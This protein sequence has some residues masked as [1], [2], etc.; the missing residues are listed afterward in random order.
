M[1]RGLRARR[2]IFRGFGIVINVVLLVIHTHTDC[3]YLRT[4]QSFVCIAMG[5][6]VP[7]NNTR[8]CKTC[9]ECLPLDEFCPGS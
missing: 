8:Y 9:Q 7:E 2:V 1:L 5:V 3:C 4:P 6:T